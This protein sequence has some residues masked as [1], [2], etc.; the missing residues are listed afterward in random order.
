[1]D[2]TPDRGNH[3]APGA[4]RDRR[5]TPRGV[6]PRR[7]HPSLEALPPERR[8]NRGACELLAVAA[9]AQVREH[10]RTEPGMQRLDQEVGGRAIGEM[11]GRAGDAMLHR[12]RVAAGAEQD[13]IVVRLEDH[14]R[15]L[16]Q[17][18]AQLVSGA[19]AGHRVKQLRVDQGLRVGVDRELEPRGV[20]QQPQ[21][22]GFVRT[23]LPANAHHVGEQNSNLSA[24]GFHAPPPRRR[25]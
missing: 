25:R 18:Q 12:W 6:L 17:Q 22:A 10:D 20:A 8:L 7:V 13:L 3:A 16:A 1:M 19:V 14:G 11:T 15:E 9:L 24:L 23:H 2:T 21:H 4:V 5:I